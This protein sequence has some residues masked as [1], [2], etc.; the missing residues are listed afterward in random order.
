M[1]MYTCDETHGCG[2]KTD[3]LFAVEVKDWDLW[4][5]QAPDDADFEN[6]EDAGI[7]TV[8]VCKGCATTGSWYD[9]EEY[10]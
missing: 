5:E 3:Q 6:D 7:A 8:K 1:I 10:S 9:P 4:N 2:R